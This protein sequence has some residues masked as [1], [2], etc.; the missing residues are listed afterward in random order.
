LKIF[1]L[2]VG[3]YAGTLSQQHI[4]GPK[5]KEAFGSMQTSEAQVLSRPEATLEIKSA[6][7]TVLALKPATVD[8]SQISRQLEARLA[9][10]PGFFDNDAVVL[11]LTALEAGG[12]IPDFPGLVVEARRHGAYIAGVRG[13]TAYQREAAAHAGLGSFSAPGTLK[14]EK[15]QRTPGRPARIVDRPVRG[16]QQIYAKGGDLV[17]LATVN[18]GAEVLADGHVHV[19]APLRGRALAG[20]RGDSG[21]RIFCQSFEAELVAVTGIYRTP[22]EGDAFHGKPV[23]IFLEGERL[24]IAPL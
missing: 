15:P 22:E 17:V 23:Q 10:T 6:S 11:D 7:F 24:M 3:S 18:P 13:G 8:T 12:G 20:V 2:K 14:S 5:C 9:E 16:G 19:Y 1:F 4:R 21:S